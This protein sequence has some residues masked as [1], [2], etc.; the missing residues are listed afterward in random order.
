[1]DTVMTRGCDSRFID[2]SVLQSRCKEKPVQ[3]YSMKATLVKSQQNLEPPKALE[4]KPGWGKKKKEPRQKNRKYQSFTEGLKHCPAG[5]SLVTKDGVLLSVWSNV[6]CSCKI[7][8]L[9]FSAFDLN[10]LTLT[11]VPTEK[12]T[13]KPKQTWE[14]LKPTE[15]INRACCLAHHKP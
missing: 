1:M 12:R 15:S 6:I 9:N 7:K 13:K 10:F 4:N 2:F 5:R 8:C 11:I 3:T 14:N